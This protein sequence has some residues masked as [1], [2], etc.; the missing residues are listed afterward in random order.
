MSPVYKLLLFV[1]IF[2]LILIM[3]YSSF[4]YLNRKIRGSETGWELTGYSLILLLVNAGLLFVGLFVLIKAYG[5]L[6]DVE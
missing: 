4:R 5:F 1:I 2:G 6:A 3:G